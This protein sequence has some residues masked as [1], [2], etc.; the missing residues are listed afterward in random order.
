[1]VYLGILKS[2]GFRP[3]LLLMKTRGT[4]PVYFCLNMTLALVAS[5][6]LNGVDV[7]T[8]GRIFVLSLLSILTITLSGYVCN[9]LTD[10]E[11]DRLNKLDRPLVTGEASIKHA[12]HLVIVLGILGLATAYLINLTV[13]LLMTT[14][15]ALFILYSLP[16]LRLKSRFLINKLTTCAGIIVSYLVGGAATGT[17]QSPIFLMAMYGFINGLVA[18]TLIDLR[19]TEGDKAY[20]VKTPAI[21]WG[22]KFLIRFSITLVVLM[23]IIMIGSY[24]YLGFNMAFLALASCGFIA[25]IGVIYPLFNRWNEPFY[26]EKTVHKKIIPIFMSLQVLTVLGIAL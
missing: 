3:Y 18:S 1:M 22:T 4:G 12:R 23:G 15:F 14:Y 5:S 25:W 17:I 8:F 6:K 7:L 26:V 19:D 9:D 2:R 24:S 11:I 21:A 13:F 20:K 10:V 16:P